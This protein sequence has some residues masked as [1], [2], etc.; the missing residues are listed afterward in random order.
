MAT[1][2]NGIVLSTVKT[3]KTKERINYEDININNYIKMI[4]KWVWHYKKKYFYLNL[5]FEDLE[6]QALL[7]F[8]LTKHEFNPYLG[9]GFSTVL[10]INLKGYLL[11][12]CK[13]HKNKKENEVSPFKIKTEGNEEI[14]ILDTIPA[15]TT[16]TLKYFIEFAEENLSKKSF[17]VLQWIF[18]NPIYVCR[19]RLKIYSNRLGIPLDEL[20]SILNEIGVFWKKKGKYFNSCCGGVI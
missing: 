2:G 15:K 9:T 7:I 13:A 12:Y 8:S 20:K 11:D 1:N 16:D 4:Y 5:E 10:T 6:A 18:E 17:A 19:N 14:N 3:I